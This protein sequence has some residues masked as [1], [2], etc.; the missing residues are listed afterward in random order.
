[1]KKKKIA[2]LGLVFLSVC[3]AGLIGNFD[4]VKSAQPVDEMAFFEQ[5]GAVLKD[6]SDDIKTEPYVLPNP[7]ENT[8]IVPKSEVDQA[9]EFYKLQ[10]ITDAEAKVK[11]EEYAK[12]VML[13]IMK[14]Y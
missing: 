6:D 1:M 2:A 12:N 10:D 5:W 8:I 14:L 7:D 4:K 11:A 13:Y 3:I 9:I